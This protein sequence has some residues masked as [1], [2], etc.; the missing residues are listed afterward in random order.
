MGALLLGLLLFDLGLV[1]VTF[2]LPEVWFRLLHD[3]GPPSPAPPFFL[4]T[5]AQWA[6][7]ALVQALALWRW[8]RDPGWLAAVAGV[9]LCDVLTDWTYLAIS[10]QV[11]P[12]G[13][14]ALIG[15]GLANGALAAVLWRAYR[16]R[17]GGSLA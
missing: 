9:R 7:F 2:G 3:S 16:S 5:G 12:L 11:T 15:A 8:R 10:E 4:R 13:W 17:A 6:G 1:V 14:V